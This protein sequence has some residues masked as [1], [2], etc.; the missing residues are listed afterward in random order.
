MECINQTNWN[1]FLNGLTQAQAQA[2]S[3]TNSTAYIYNE[4]SS[5]YWYTSSSMTG[6]M[7]ICSCLKYGFTFAAINPS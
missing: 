2:E 6:K 4:A 5:I 1:F 7:C 3:K